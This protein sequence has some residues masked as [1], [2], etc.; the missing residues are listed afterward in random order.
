[1]RVSAP[2]GAGYNAILGVDL[3]YDG[4][5][6]PVAGDY[7]VYDASQYLGITFWARGTGLDAGFDL[8]VACGATTLISYGGH[9]NTG[10][11]VD[12]FL[13]VLPTTDWASY[14][15]PFSALTGGSSTFN[16]AELTH[17]QFRTSGFPTGAIELWI[18]DLAFYR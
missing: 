18:D 14:S 6:V 4:A 9:C 11:C 12:N 2:S 17:F 13:H 16:K 1:M 7:G 3:Q 10:S 5:T 8:L 15:I